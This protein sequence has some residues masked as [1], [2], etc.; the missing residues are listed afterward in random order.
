MR[1]LWHY[2]KDLVYNPEIVFKRPVQ[3]ADQ[4]EVAL[5]VN[6]PLLKNMQEVGV[7]IPTL[8]DVSRYNRI[9]LNKSDIA[10]CSATRVS[11]SREGV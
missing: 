7:R 1:K 4:C 10:K 8:T 9:I 11:N 5:D 2:T 6:N 3:N